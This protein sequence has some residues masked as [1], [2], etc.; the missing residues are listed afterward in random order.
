MNIGTLKTTFYN[1]IKEYFAGATV[2]WGAVPTEVKPTLPFVVLKTGNLIRSR[3]G[4]ILDNVKFTPCKMPVDINLYTK[5]KRNQ[6]TGGVYYENTATEDLNDFLN[7]LLSP[8]AQDKFQQN[9]IGLELE[10]GI[11]DLTQVLDEEY[12]FRAMQEVFLNFM[13][14]ASGYA[15]I[16]RTNWQQTS[17]GGGTAA[18]AGQLQYDIEEAEIEFDKG[19]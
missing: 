9:N 15:G 8:Y 7:F 16:T 2:I 1:L 17:S 4:I 14:E 10:G 12:E 11:N 6:V 18:L 3:D 19:E 5:G 13:D